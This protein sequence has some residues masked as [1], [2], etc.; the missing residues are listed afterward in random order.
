MAMPVVEARG[1]K[2]AMTAP[3][4]QRQETNGWSVSFMMPASYTLKTLPAPI[5]PTL[6]VREV[7]ARRMAVIR[8]SGVW[9]E[10]RYLANKDRLESWI[11]EKGLT[12]I[13]QPVWARYNP[14][15]TLWF[16]RRNEVLIPVAK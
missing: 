14:P 9:S 1:E 5:D 10:E 7:P 8:Y 13:G 12:A 2:I 6:T 3:V 16:L 15:F 11:R 4:G